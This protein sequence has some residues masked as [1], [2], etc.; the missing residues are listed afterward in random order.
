M[1]VPT[2]ILDACV[3]YPAPV[4]DL[5]IQLAQDG[6]FHA[7][8]SRRIEDEWMENLL[9][10][11][12]DLSRSRLNRTIQYMRDAVL[13][14][15]ATPDSTIERELKVTAKED[16][17]VFS[18]AANGECRFIVT[19]NLK[20]FNRAEASKFHLTVINP[21]EFILWL[22][23]DRE[24]EVREA[25]ERICTRLAK[26]PKTVDQYFDTLENNKLQKTVKA[27]RVAT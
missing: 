24:N 1:I 20:D 8:W 16:R 17:H 18:A 13:D 5:L 26:P 4:R 3:L 23:K 2:A 22:M 11:R 25:A 9:R 14:W 19:W 10:N 15:E 21:D 27:L 6:L 7:K 12:T